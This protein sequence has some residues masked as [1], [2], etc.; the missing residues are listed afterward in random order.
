M[1]RVALRLE[2]RDYAT[3]FRPLIGAGSSVSRNDVVLMGALRLN[4]HRATQSSQ[5]VE[6]TRR[7]SPPVARCTARDD[8][9]LH[10]CL[11]TA[12]HRAPPRRP[13]TTRLSRWR[14][15]AALIALSLVPAARRHRRG[16][17]SSP[18]ARP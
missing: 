5:V 11:R 17:R 16:W 15:P 18:A 14:L 13:M 9:L 6:P 7:A 4:R 1:G 12:L 3:G 2:A 8:P 10:A